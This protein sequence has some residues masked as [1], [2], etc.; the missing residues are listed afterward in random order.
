M[1]SWRRRG[2]LPFS[3]TASSAP[4]CCQMCTIGSSEKQQGA[5]DCMLHYLIPHR[6]RL[7]H[8]LQLLL[9][10]RSCA[11]STNGSSG[12]VNPSWRG[13]IAGEGL[14]LKDRTH[15]AAQERYTRA[16]AS[17]LHHP[18]DKHYHEERKRARSR[19][20]DNIA[21]RN[22]T[23]IGPGRTLV[24]SRRCQPPRTRQQ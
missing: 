5:D 10:T 21:G 3:G 4:S 11:A 9:G 13:Q 7:P 14:G 22:S 18:H 15:R 20:S 1:D 6:W 12:C 8:R 17:A 16:G 2:S 19:R 24:P 23:P